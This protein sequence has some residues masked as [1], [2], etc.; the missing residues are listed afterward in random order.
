LNV[1][2]DMNDVGYVESRAWG[3]LQVIQTRLRRAGLE[4]TLRGVNEDLKVLMDSTGLSSVFRV[5]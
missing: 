2:L 4:L 1:T 3:C 5:I